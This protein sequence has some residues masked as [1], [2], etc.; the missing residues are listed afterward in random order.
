MLS[1]VPV[2][3]P[4]LASPE[5]S[6]DQRAPLLQWATQAEDRR[7]PWRVS[8]TAAGLGSELSMV[9][10]PAIAGSI[11]ALAGLSKGRRRVWKRANSGLL[12]SS[13]RRRASLVQAHCRGDSSLP[14]TAS[15][16][17]V[18]SQQSRRQQLLLGLAV[19]PA[20][21]ACGIAGSPAEAVAA[22]VSR[23]LEQQ[24]ALRG[25]AERFRT[26]Q[27]RL[28]PGQTNSPTLDQGQQLRGDGEADPAAL[29][30]IINFLESKA[31]A[32]ELGILGDREKDIWAEVEKSG[33][34]AAEQ[35]VFLKEY[36]SFW[37]SFNL[38]FDSAL[39]ALS[40]TLETSRGDSKVVSDIVN[41]MTLDAQSGTFSGNVDLLQGLF[42]RMT[43]FRRDRRKNFVSG[44]K[45]NAKDSLANSDAAS[46]EAAALIRTY[47]KD[48]KFAPGLS[49]LV[50]LQ[51]TLLRYLRA[52]V[53]GELPEYPDVLNQLKI[54]EESGTGVTKRKVVL[55]L[56]RIQ[57]VFSFLNCFQDEVLTS[58]EKRK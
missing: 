57:G 56:Y 28:D 53:A 8:C 50:D 46:Q 33:T 38:L 23:L 51:V 35:I 41:L 47:C 11:L 42:K 39:V 40:N 2:A 24:P 15:A 14:S 12:R 49:A 52:V 26:L 37:A 6:F 34:A 31:A 54:Y 16:A 10:S 22:G 13:R 20:A 25:F 58:I 44:L 32:D 30:A 21:G 48:G 55:L 36:Y 18:A 45:K 1:T 5:G 17:S 3:W 27:L 4:S 29:D 19:F 43:K 7:P 9:A